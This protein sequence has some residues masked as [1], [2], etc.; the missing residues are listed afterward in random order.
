[1][2]TVE[3]SCLTASGALETCSLEQLEGRNGDTTVWVDVLGPD[4]D[5]MRRLKDRFGLHPLAVE[6]SLHR[7]FRPK[8]D[9]YEEDTAFVAWMIPRLEPDEGQPGG[10][11]L[12]IDEVDFL[13]G[14]GFLISVRSG[15]VTAVQQVRSESVDAMR[16]GPAWILHDILD[17]A[18]DAV[19]PVLDTISER[20]D[21]AED[22]ML[23]AAPSKRDLAELY[24]VKRLL[25]GMRRIAGPER[26]IVRGL[27]RDE[28]VVDR[29]AYMYFQ[30]IGDHLAR[31]EDAIETYRDI[32]ASAA[33]I[34]LSSVSNRLGEIMKRLTLVATIF[35]PLTFIVGIYGMNFDYMPPKHWFWGFPVLCAIMLGIALGMV[36]WFKREDWV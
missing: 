36:W 28:A 19:F 30:D 25:L 35:M 29:Q 22:R 8:F 4:Q 9:L 32:A 16:K 12:A 7:Q 21:D 11:R 33:D 17:R 26:D 14:K 31:A 18:V 3:V 23:S 1:M 10:Q 34:Y 15:P 24:G 5:T 6:D 27:S 2:S 13:F 20:L